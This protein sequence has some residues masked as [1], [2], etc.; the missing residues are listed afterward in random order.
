MTVYSRNVLIAPLN[1][2]LGHATRC[3]PI[4]HQQIAYG[5]KVIIA[6][7]GDS[8]ALLRKEFPDL[9]YEEL[10]SYN[11]TYPSGGKQLIWHLLKM[12]NK[13]MLTIKNENLLLSNFVDKYSLDL[14]ISDNRFGMYHK[15]VFSVYITHQTN[16]QSGR[17]SAI[18]NKFHEY[19]M[20]RFNEIWIPDYEGENSLAGKLSEYNGGQVAKHI[21]ILSRFKYDESVEEKN[22]VLVVL[23]GPEPQRSFLEEKILSELD[24]VD[25]DITLILGKVEKIQRKT[26]KGN[27][28]IF[29]FLTSSDLEREMREC[30]LVVAR[31]GYSTIMDLKALK[32]KAF[33]IPTPGQGEQLYLAKYLKSKN[34]CNYVCQ[35]KFSLTEVIGLKDDFTGFS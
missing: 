33:L 3:I 13:I 12:S 11:I 28:T 16:I 10:P 4:I 30:S 27:V 23:S 8:L 5:N 20:S 34:I 17:V 24:S 29:N 9:D 21:G 15:G 26:T 6:S 35:E 31:S 18:A 7:D 19:Y 14:I 25:I 32:K 22:K 1:W 2:G